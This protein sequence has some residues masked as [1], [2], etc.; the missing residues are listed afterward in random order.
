MR[1][2]FAQIPTP[3]GTMKTFVTHPEQDGPFPAVV[4]YMDFWGAREELF[5]IARWVGTVGYY[6]MVPDLY[7]RQGTILNTMRDEQGKMMSLS[8]LDKATQEKVLEPLKKL[9]D[10]EVVDDTEAL[11]QF[12]AKEPIVRSGPKGC[13]GFC[14]GG[15]LVMRAAGRF[16]DQFKAMASLHGASLVTDREDSPHR[17][18]DK[19]QGEFY[20]GF[21]EH[22]PYTLPS[23]V[24]TITAAAQKSAAK[25]RYE[26]HKNTEHG[27][28]LPDRDIYDRKASLRDWEIIFAMFQR[29]LTPY[30]L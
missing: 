23:T 5:D 8:R 4:L 10:A 25:Y 6:C 26:I 11:L 9:K 14:L 30:R 16:P 24:T 20:F 13:V 17:L 28:A 3:A 19:F 15:R 1:E 2:Q 18:I 12:L 7:Y 29:Q 21:A 22:D 27:Y